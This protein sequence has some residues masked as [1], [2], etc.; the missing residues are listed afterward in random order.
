L[1]Q[2]VDQ[3]QITVRFD[4]FSRNDGHG[5]SDLA[6]RHRHAIGGDNDYFERVGTFLLQARLLLGLGVSACNGSRKSDHSMDCG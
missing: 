6:Q 5:R 2:Y 1:A 4:I 3:R